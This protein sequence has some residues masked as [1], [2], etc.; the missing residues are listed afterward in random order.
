MV[1]DLLQCV[2]RGAWVV[3]NYWMAWHYMRINDIIWE[4]IILG[5]YVEVTNEP[6]KVFFVIFI[7]RRYGD[8]L[9]V[10]VIW[11]KTKVTLWNLLGFK[12]KW[13]WISIYIL[14]VCMHF[15][16]SVC[17]EI[18][19]KIFSECWITYFYF[20][21]LHNSVMSEICSIMSRLPKVLSSKPHILGSFKN[22]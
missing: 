8:E 17:L 16:I 5:G 20:F 22:W 3:R 10:T 12:G 6:H 13:F 11:T 1:L 21:I 9:R 15:N 4:Y 7:G 2:T 18:A 19:Q 14:H